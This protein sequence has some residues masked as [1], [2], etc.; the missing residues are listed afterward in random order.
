M[1]QINYNFIGYSLSLKSIDMN[2]ANNIQGQM[3]EFQP[4]AYLEKLC[5]WIGREKHSNS[6]VNF[7]R[8]LSSFS[9]NR[10]IELFE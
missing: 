1:A 6:I 8:T 9:L 4:W 3:V 10:M 5:I 2:L 7:P